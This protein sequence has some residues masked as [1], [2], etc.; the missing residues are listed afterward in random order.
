MASSLFTWSEC[1]GVA[2]DL[3]GSAQYGWK[4][5]KGKQRQNLIRLKNI[6]DSAPIQSP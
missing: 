2:A 6:A 3:H 1:Q 4:N 5:W